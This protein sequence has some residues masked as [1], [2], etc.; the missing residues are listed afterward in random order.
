MTVKAE[1]PDD[2]VEW[3][4]ELSPADLRT[5]LAVLAV[6]HPKDVRRILNSVAPFRDT[7]DSIGGAS[8]YV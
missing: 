7:T 2:L 4:V 1:P 5:V 8:A 3:I 6:R